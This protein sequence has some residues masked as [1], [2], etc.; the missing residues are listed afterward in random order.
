MYILKDISKLAK[1]NDEGMVESSQ[2]SFY[3]TFV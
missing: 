1:I 3:V 2:D